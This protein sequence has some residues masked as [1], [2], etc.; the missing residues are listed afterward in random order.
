MADKTQV[1]RVELVVKLDDTDVVNWIDKLV[2]AHNKTLKESIIIS[3]DATPLDMEDGNN[4]WIKDIL[5]DYT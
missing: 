5:N 3:T 1:H 4:K 2:D